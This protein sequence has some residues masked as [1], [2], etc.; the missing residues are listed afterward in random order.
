LGAGLQVVV[1]CG[2]LP[3]CG[4]V[5]G[6]ALPVGADRAARAGRGC[7][8]GRGLPVTPSFFGMRARF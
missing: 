5:S 3:L 2:S 1:W 6:R 4:A 8:D 7:D